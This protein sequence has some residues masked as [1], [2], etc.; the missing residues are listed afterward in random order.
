MK[1]IYI[2]IAIV[3]VVAVF[4]LFYPKVKGSFGAVSSSG[5][6]NSMTSWSSITLTPSSNAAT[7]T[8]ILNSGA[9]DRAILGSYTMCTSEV[10]VGLPLTS[11]AWA[12]TAATTSTSS[13]GLQ[14]NTNYIANITIAT[15]TG[16]TFVAST[17]EGVIANWSRIWPVNTYLTFALNASS[18]ASCSFGVEWMPL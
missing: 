18:T 9:S 2:A 11:G 15:T 13:L 6:Y 8:S 4:G 10:A 12:M 5:A 1:K 3:F 17:T 14:G 7:T 16:T